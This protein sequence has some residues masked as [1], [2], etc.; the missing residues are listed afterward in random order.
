M[1]VFIIYC[2][3]EEIECRSRNGML[4]DAALDGI[5]ISLK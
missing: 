1:I 5:C 4:C 2:K 3:R